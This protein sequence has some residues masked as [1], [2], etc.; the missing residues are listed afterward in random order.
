MTVEISDLKHLEKV[1]KSLRG[2]DGVLDVETR[3]QG[4]VAGRSGSGSTPARATDLSA[5]VAA[6]ASISTRASLGSRATCTVARAGYGSGKIRAVHL[7]HRRE[8]VHVGEKDRR[9]DDVGERQAAGFEER[10][11]DCRA[12]GGSARRCRRRPSVPVAGSS[13][14]WPET[15]SSW[16]ARTAGEYGPIAFGASGLEI[17]CSCVDRR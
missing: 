15:N 1:I 16:P 10:A 17:A 4:R 2:V 5:L 12:R 7:V 3:G 11:D 6:I 14:T 8:V 9:P 13:G